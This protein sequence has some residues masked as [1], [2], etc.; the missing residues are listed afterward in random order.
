MS[1]FLHQHVHWLGQ[2]PDAV[3]CYTLA[4]PPCLSRSLI[5]Q[6]VRSLIAGDDWLCRISRSSWQN[7]ASQFQTSS[8]K[9][10]GKAASLW[11]TKAHRLWDKYRS[12]SVVK[13]WFL[14][15]YY[16]V[17]LLLCLM[18]CIL[19]LPRSKAHSHRVL[20]PRSCL[21]SSFEIS[22]QHWSK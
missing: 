13:R 11:T 10:N 17:A 15:L 3:Q 21:L 12:K 22:C 2:Y 6:F 9:V 1:H 19:F 18:S 14:S 5:P 4:C 20:C 8:S 16:I 7:F